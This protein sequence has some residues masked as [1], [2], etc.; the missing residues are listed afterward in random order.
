MV[1]K[2]NSLKNAAKILE[3]LPNTKI[4]VFAVAVTARSDQMF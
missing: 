2:A 3:M 4:K 1:I